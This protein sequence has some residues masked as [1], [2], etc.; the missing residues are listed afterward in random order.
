VNQLGNVVERSKCTGVTLS[1]YLVDESGFQLQVGRSVDTKKIPNLQIEFSNDS[2]YIAAVTSE[3][4]NCVWIINVSELAVV[5]VLQ[6]ASPVR[7]FSWHD[8]SPILVVATD[9]SNIFVWQP[10]G[11]LSIPQPAVNDPRLVRWAPG[12]DTLLIAGSTSFCLAVP[13][14]ATY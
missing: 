5:A 9:A 7:S 11:C 3:Y 14:W 2:A 1:Y 12:N 4:P 13:D 8:V 10:S 6:Q